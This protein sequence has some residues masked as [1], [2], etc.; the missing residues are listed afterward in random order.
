[1][2]G[3][4]DLMAGYDESNPPYELILSDERYTSSI[5][6]DRDDVKIGYN[7]DLVGSYITAAN[8]SS[9]DYTQKKFPSILYNWSESGERHID[10]SKL[11][12]IAHPS[13]IINISNE[14]KVCWVCGDHNYIIHLY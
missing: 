3:V 7:D 4:V 5:Y 11:N 1:M 10:R 8:S 9:S 14:R 6:S 12:E 13:S 2:K